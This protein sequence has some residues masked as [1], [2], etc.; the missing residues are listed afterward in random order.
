M[1]ICSSAS[2]EGWIE[3]GYTGRCKKIFLFGDFGIR[4]YIDDP[5]NIIE[6]KTPFI[7]AIDGPAGAGKTTTAKLA[8]NKLNFIY[9]DTGAMYRAVA[10]AAIQH[11]ISIDDARAVCELLPRIH[12]E[13]QRQNNDQIT[14]LDGKNVEAAIRTPEMSKAASDVSKIPCVREAMVNLQ[15]TAGLRSKG[16]VL[17]GRDI[18]TVVFPDAPLK[19]FLVASVEARA[20]R[21]R[22]DFLAAGSALDLETLKAQITDRDHNDSTRANSPLLKALDAVEI[23][24][25]N[26]TIYEQVQIILD[27]AQQ[28]MK[29]SEKVAA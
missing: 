16:A 3:K 25:T 13:L 21:R 14:L 23:D 5:M 22:K 28:R 26:L 24:T 10:L 8:A 29:K 27:L 15:R 12:I 20:E 17:E 19:I 11:D 6:N 2:F 9:I 18:G 7:I 4:M 1:G